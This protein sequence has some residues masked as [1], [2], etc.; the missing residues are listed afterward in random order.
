MSGDFNSNE[1]KTSGQYYQVSFKGRTEVKNATKTV[2]ITFQTTFFFTATSTPNYESHGSA[3]VSL[4]NSS[5]TT[6]ETS[7]STTAT[8]EATAKTG[9]EFIGWGTTSTATTYES[10]A[11]PYKPTISN[12]TAGSTATK[13]LYAIFKPVFNFTATANKINGSYGTATASVTAS[14]VLGA[15]PSSTSASTTATF[16]ATPATGCTFV[17]WY[18]DA[19]HTN[20]AS[21]S[22]TYTP[23]ITN[24]SVGSTANLTLYAWFKSNQTLTWTQSTYD[25]NVV[26]GM[27]S[28]G[29]AA[30][31]A[32]SGL[33]V[34][35]TSSDDNVASVNGSGDVIGVS[36]SL[37]DVTITATQAGDDEFNPVSAT[38]TFRVIN[39]YEATFTPSGFS[40]SSPTIYVD[41]TPTITCANTASDFTYTSSDPTVVAIAKSGDVITLTALKVGTSTI[42]L[43]QPNNSTHSGVTKTYNITVALVPNTLAVALAAQSV[44]VDGT[45]AVTFTDRNNTATDIIGTVTD[46]T[47]S[48]SVNNGTDVITYANGVI[49]AKNAGTAKI[50]FTQAETAKY[51]GFT[52]ST[53]DITV[54]KLANS[55]SVTLNGGSATNIKLKYSATATLA[56]SST[57]TAS[58]PTVTR[59]SGHYTTLSGSTITA[60][61]TQGTDIYEI[62]QAET[63]LY[64]AGYASFTIRVNNSDEAVGYVLN[65]ATEYSHGTGSGV[66][67]TYTLSG[68][69]ETL[70]YTASTDWAAIYYHLYVEYSTDNSNWV[71]AQDNQSLSDSN[72][73]FSCA[74]PEEARYVQFR[75]PG[76]G[77]LTKYVSN[78]KVT[79]KTYVRASSD[80]TALGSIYTDQT[81][82]ATFTVSYSS[83]NGGNINVSSS[84]AHFA[85]STTEL[86]VA[87]NSDGTHTFTVTYTPD[88]DQLGDESAVITV[89]DL[90]YSQQIT[91]TATAAKRANTLAV[92]GAQ[93]L[94][95]DDVV[96]NVYSSKNSTSTLNYSFSREGV[97]TF[98]S[99]TGTLTAV[100]AGSTT[101][102][103]TQAENDYYY[104]TTKTIAI[105]VTRYDQ[106]ITW[107]TEIS[108]EQRTFDVGDALATNTATASSGLAV[109]YSSSNATA[110]EVN[111]STGALTALAGG[112]NIAI[113]ATQAGNYK[114]NEASITRYFNVIN[115]TE[116]I[117]TT[118]LS[119]SGTNV[120][121]IGSDDITIGCS[122]T[123]TAS[124]L[125]VT[126][127]DDALSVTFGGNTFTLHALAEGNVTVTLTRAEDEGYYAVSKTY[128]IQVTKPVLALDPAEAPVISYSEYSSVTLSRTL[129]AGYSTLSL[130][131]DTSLDDILGDDRDSDEA[132]WVAQLSAVTYNARDGYTLYFQKV[133]DG[134]IQANEPYVLFLTTEVQNPSWTGTISVSAATPA[135]HAATTGYTTGGIGTYADWCMYA[136]YTPAM[137]MDGMYGIVNDLGA[138]KL[139][140]TGSTLNA[141]AAYIAPPAGN[142]GVKT[143][144][145]FVGEQGDVTIVEGLPTDGTEV[146]APTTLYTIDGRRVT[147]SH[148]GIVIERRADGTTRKVLR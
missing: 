84:N 72:K 70:S 63:Y 118:T 24:S 91:L 26:N 131:F 40:G 11:N 25:P 64:E 7:A 15:S 142:A 3:K 96:N 30:A 69:G 120:F 146:T 124:A 135:A 76:G 78:V 29:V 54:S 53:Y 48:S 93:A 100:G 83:T 18:T 43:T 81:A 98:D 113:T 20:L 147:S 56:Y 148:R 19:A 10:T 61:S 65:E 41:D 73:D 89:G 75:F 129:K 38:R 52:S 1:V 123:L 45:I 36:A 126:G 21:T 137:A 97:A 9:Y 94:K 71:E 106:T 133:A 37:S 114:Y 121:P 102:T 62:T 99:S 66:V 31:T 55:I 122:A 77:T 115:K 4:A 32:S 108:D 141:Y 86:T 47:L 138:L 103:L 105:E 8:F 110:L 143:R 14:K 2:T 80:K 134:T 82:T 104:G 74:V 34:T 42:T 12:S 112:S 79:R 49:T 130:P 16:T 44:Q 144:S 57:N 107:D 51:E 85:P 139:G 127:D 90:F 23:T 39:K 58:T 68:P 95:V 88:P 116:A 59:T 109:T 28:T 60:G 27:T 35:Y 5:I 6:T 13:T 111:A 117:V 17:G 50:T 119:E 140:T 101:L 46:Q 125:T 33:T 145:A 67:H 92:V 136:N 132:Y 128:V 87:N 22:A